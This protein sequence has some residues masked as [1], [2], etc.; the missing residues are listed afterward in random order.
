MRHLNKRFEGAGELA[1]ALTAQ[2]DSGKE[3]RREGAC[4]EDQHLQFSPNHLLQA[5]GHWA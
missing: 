2:E 3:A 4:W 5:G 1:D